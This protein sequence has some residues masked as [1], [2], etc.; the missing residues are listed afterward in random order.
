M[1]K[2]KAE[3]VIKILTEALPFI[4]KFSKSIHFKP[5]SLDDINERVRDMAKDGRVQ[6]IELNLMDPYIKAN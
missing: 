2:N 6:N 4:Q 5:S 3:Q 1:E